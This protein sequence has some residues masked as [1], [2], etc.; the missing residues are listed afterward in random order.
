M[1]TP[2]PSVDLTKIEPQL[3]AA[4]LGHPTGPLGVAVAEKLNTTNAGAYAAAC[5]KLGVHKN[6]PV[7]G[8]NVEPL[9]GLVIENVSGS[10]SG[11]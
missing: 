11:S 1:T 9:G 6:T 7:V 3:L 4:Q 5:E 10:R 8:L 2:G